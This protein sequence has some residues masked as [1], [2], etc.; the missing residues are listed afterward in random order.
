MT[1]ISPNTHFHHQR[2]VCGLT[3]KPG[4]TFLD[5]CSLS[6]SRLEIC[7][8]GSSF[9]NHLAELEWTA[10]RLAYCIFVKRSGTQYLRPALTNFSSRADV[11]ISAG[12]DFY[13]SSREGLND[14][15]EATQAGQVLIYRN[16]GPYTF[17]PK[18][19]LFKSAQHADIVVGSGN[20]TEGGLFTNY[21]AS[22][23]VSLDLSEPEDAAFLQIVEAT[24]D[25]WAQPK[26]GLCYVLNAEFLETARGFW[27]GSF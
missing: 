7:A 25:Q 11:R 4:W 13:G 20:L 27:P 14:L 1:P 15:L 19:Y 5:A 18:V 10:F 26:Q 6:R 21:E 24:L 9:S 8:L 17:H 23:A 2:P 3:F 22:L 16:S 12:I